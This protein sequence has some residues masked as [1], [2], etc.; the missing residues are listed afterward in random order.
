[1]TADAWSHQIALTQQQVETLRAALPHPTQWSAALKDAVDAL[2]TALEAL[3]R[4]HAEQQ[5][6]QP[7]HTQRRTTI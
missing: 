7:L 1:M 4:A 3:H 5:Q 2:E 6:L